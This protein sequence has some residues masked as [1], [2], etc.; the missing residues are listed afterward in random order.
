MM[1]SSLMDAR[2]VP[3]AH[4]SPLASQLHL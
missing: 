3:A 4:I 1:K 2:K